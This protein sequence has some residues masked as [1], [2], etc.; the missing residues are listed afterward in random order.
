[1]YAARKWTTQPGLLYYIYITVQ[2]FVHYVVAFNVHCELMTCSPSEQQLQSAFHKL[3]NGVDVQTWKLLKPSY[4]GESQ[5]TTNDKL[6][7]G[8]KETS[9]KLAMFTHV[10]VEIRQKAA[11]DY[12]DVQYG[13]L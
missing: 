5:K 7:A 3:S 1:M 9:G 8:D 4:L 6:V 10:D 13:S 11:A 12:V 2:W